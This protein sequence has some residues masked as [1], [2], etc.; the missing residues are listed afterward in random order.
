[1]CKI[2]H[3]LENNHQKTLIIVGGGASG[4]FLAA[5]LIKQSYLKIIILEQAKSLLQKVKISGGGRCNVTHECFEISELVKFYPRGNKVLKSVFSKFSPKDTIEWF[6]NRGVQL[7]TENDGRIFPVSNDSQTIIDG[8]LR[9]VTK[10]KVEIKTQQTVNS[11]RKNNEN[12]FTI[13]TTND[14]FL[15]DYVV[16]ASG[17]SPKMCQ[18]IEQ[19]QH[20]IVPLVPSLFSFNCNDN[21]LKD[22]AGTSFLTC[23]IFIKG[24][25]FKETGAMLITHWG[26]SGPCVLKLSSWYAKEFS[27]LNYKFEVIINF[28]GK[29]LNEIKEDL[30]NFKTNNGKKNVFKNKFVNITQRFWERILQ[31]SSIS[32]IKNYADLNKKE[33]QNLAENLTQYTLKV[34][35]KN[36]NKDEFVTCGGVELSEIDFKTMQSKIHQNLFFSG[37]ILNI[38]A[39]TGGFN[40][41]ACWSEAFIISEFFNLQTD[42]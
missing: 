2:N 40:F 11:I 31:I 38:D 8:L 23:E 34:S 16:I 1:M 28:I 7:K 37:E 4:M 42:L 24:T 13:K 27:E 6:E 25:K 39:L 35:G 15:A 20:K 22:L 5:N 12:Q 33:I 26:I 17:S 14:N 41:Q 36:T 21:L 29:S 18:I 32:E 9:E 19:L 30:L 10:N 3:F